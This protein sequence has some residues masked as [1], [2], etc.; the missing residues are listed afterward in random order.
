M[1][2]K[3][4]RRSDVGASYRFTNDKV[5][6]NEGFINAVAKINYTFLST[7]CIPSL[8][9]RFHACHRPDKHR[10]HLKLSRMA[11]NKPYGDNARKGA[12]KSRSQ[13]FNPKTGHWVKRDSNT[14]QFMDQK[15]S[16][17]QPFKGVRKEK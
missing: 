15:T 17:N 11:T 7:N 5:I 1:G 4:P 3:K 12:V 14:G 6:G 10:L 8:F 9:S 16:D 13:V 2:E